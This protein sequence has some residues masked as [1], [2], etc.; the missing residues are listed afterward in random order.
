MEQM[1]RILKSKLFTLSGYVA[2]VAAALLF[3]GFSGLDATTLR[4]LDSVFAT[5]VAVALLLSA[6]AC[7]VGFAEANTFP[8]VEQRPEIFKTAIAILFLLTIV[9]G[10]WLLLDRSPQF[11]RIPRTA[12]ALGALLLG[13][14]LIMVNAAVA[15]FWE[16]RKR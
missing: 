9:L 1:Q 7:S 15:R 6:A 12:A 5:C 14:G 2:A 11:H 10:G 4:I 8:T 16:R 13:S 3:G